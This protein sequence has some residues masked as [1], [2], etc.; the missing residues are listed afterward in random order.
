VAPEGRTFIFDR[1]GATIASSASNDDLVVKSAAAGLARLTGSSGFPEAA[2]EFRFDHV[3]AKPLSRD[4][5]LA[6]ATTYRDDRG[7][8]HWILVTAMPESF[9]LAGVHLGG[10]RTAMVFALALVLSLVLAAGLASIVTA[11]LRRIARVTQNMARGDLSA[12]APGSRLE[13]LDGLAQS[14]NDMAGRLKTSFDALVGEVEMRKHRERELEGAN[15]CARARTGCSSR[16]LRPGSHLGLGRSRIGCGTPRC[17]G[18]RVAKETFSGVFDVVTMSR[19]DDWR[20]PTPHR[21]AWRPRA[22]PTSG[23]GSRWQYTDHSGSGTDHPQRQSRPWS[24]STGM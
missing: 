4:T 20:V 15:G 3:T 13:E 2:T 1:T 7:G 22:D 21:V 18:L 23:Y 6:Y 17:T 19:A 9:Y 8:H 24:A 11:P 16:S 5:W 14:F 12:Q 10:S